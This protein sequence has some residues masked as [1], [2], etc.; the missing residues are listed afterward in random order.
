MQEEPQLV[1]REHSDPSL[2]WSRRNPPYSAATTP[3]N[4]LQSTPASTP[5]NAGWQGQ[6]PFGEG[7]VQQARQQDSAKPSRFQRD[8]PTGTNSSVTAWFQFCPAPEGVMET[9][10][11]RLDCEDS[12]CSKT[13]GDQRCMLDS[14]WHCKQA[15]LAAQKTASNQVD[16]HPFQD[17]LCHMLIQTLLSPFQ[18]ML[19]QVLGWTCCSSFRDMLCQRVACN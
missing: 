9:C 16:T 5:K 11:D 19:C 7:S 2:E 6:G 15:T 8:A 4:S 13:M 12:A 10:K 17:L 3:A 18:D 14:C 1:A